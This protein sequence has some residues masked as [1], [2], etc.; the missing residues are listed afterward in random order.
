[1]ACGQ[2]RLAVAG[3]PIVTAAC[4]CDDCQAGAAMIEALPEARPFRDADGG[5]YM[6]LYR[7]DRYRVLAGDERLVRMK[8]REK[9]LTVRVG[10]TCCNSAWRAGFGAGGIGDRYTGPA[11]TARR[12]RWGCACRRGSRPSRRRS[13]GTCRAIAGFRCGSSAG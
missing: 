8:L 5:T 4:Y 12:R 9:S 3:A 7:K 10:V 1:C 6:A 11:M 13:R 2:V